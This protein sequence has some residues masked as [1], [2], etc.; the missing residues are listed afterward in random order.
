MSI[1]I[2]VA[3]QQ[4]VAGFSAQENA[5]A[6]LEHVDLENAKVELCAIHGDHQ[7]GNKIY[8]A[9][10]LEGAGHQ[11]VGLYTDP[12]KASS[13]AGGRGKVGV[14]TIDPPYGSHH[15]RN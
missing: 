2:I 8:Y 12:G 1:H 10:R 4:V 11:F 14:L 6:Y 13:A 5:N 3:D 7:E 15:D 9:E